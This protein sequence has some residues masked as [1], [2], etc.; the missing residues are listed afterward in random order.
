VKGETNAKAH[1]E[2]KR[3]RFPL[4]APDDIR[5]IASAAAKIMVQ[6]ARYPVELERMTGL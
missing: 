2:K 6:G 3:A 1:L 4:L 5:R